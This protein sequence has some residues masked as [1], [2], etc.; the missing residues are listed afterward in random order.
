MAFLRDVEAAYRDV[1]YHN[2]RH[3]ATV[4]RSVFAFCKQPDGLARCLSEELQFALVL[5]GLVHDVNHPGV[6]SSFLLRTS[7]DH[8]SDHA[9]PKAMSTA[10]L[11]DKLVDKFDG[12]AH[13]VDLGSL[14][15]NFASQQREQAKEKLRRR[16]K[17]RAARETVLE[18]TKHRPASVESVS[19]KFLQAEQGADG[20]AARER[21]KRRRILAKIVSLGSSIRS[22]GAGLPVKLTASS[23]SPSSSFSSPLSSS[24]APFREAGGLDS[25]SSSEDEDG[26]ATVPVFSP[27]DRDLAVRY[28]D[29]SPLENMHMAVTFCLL[30]RES[31]SFLTQE[32]LAAIRSVLVKAVLGTDMALHGQ[33]M[34]RLDKLI[35]NLKAPVGAPKQTPWY[36]PV[37]PPPGLKG[38]SEKA[39]ALGLQEGF[40]VELFLHAADI[41]S[42]A[43]PFEQF[44]RWNQLVTEEFLE[45]GDL[46]LAE[47]GHLISPPAGFS[48]LATASAQHSFTRYF[49]Q[50][51]SRPLFEKLHELTRIG[52]DGLGARP[53]PLDRCLSAPEVESPRWGSF[54]SGAVD[55]GTK[56]TLLTTAR[57]LSS[58]VRGRLPSMGTLAE[59][60]LLA[61]VNIGPCIANLDSNIARFDAMKPS[62]DPVASPVASPV[63]SPVASPVA[64][65]VSSSVSSSVVAPAAVGGGVGDA[66]A[67]ARRILGEASVDDAV[68]PV[69]RRGLFGQAAA[70]PFQEPPPSDEKPADK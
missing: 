43:M 8:L 51:L 7:L 11:V 20:A 12:R 1:P 36:W 26:S 10:R 38:D 6:T 54:D 55:E 19:D 66:A 21:L 5:A 47:F 57:L 4:G 33:T 48:R 3:G 2:H 70:D 23:S 53:K 42:P 18:S 69:K 28:N 31:N 68:V 29:Q 63:S 61:N 62:P 59:G 45:Q 41:G 67:E 9:L 24:S 32:T 50:F 17:R 22:S 56:M 13:P 49:I 35:E 44:S 39:W 15:A 30:R 52:A 64:S 16:S 58:S 46:E 25:E 27:F 60:N 14:S 40:A 34:T 37:K 65:P